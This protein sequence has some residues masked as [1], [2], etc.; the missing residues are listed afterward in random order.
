MQI[1]HPHAK[2]KMLKISIEN[3]FFLKNAIL[4]FPWIGKQKINKKDN[5]LFILQN[6]SKLLSDNIRSPFLYLN[7]AKY[8]YKL[9]FKKILSASN[10]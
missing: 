4:V 1:Q 10:E 9:F 2:R 7:S 5:L 8:G 6:I 3:Y